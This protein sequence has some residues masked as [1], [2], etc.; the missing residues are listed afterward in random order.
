MNPWW[1][2]FACFMLLGVRV[3]VTFY[4]NINHTHMYL[5][6]LTC[7]FLSR[8]SKVLDIIMFNRWAACGVIVSCHLMPRVGMDSGAE[9]LSDYHAQHWYSQTVWAPQLLEEVGDI[10][11]LIFIE[12]T[13]ERNL[14]I[15]G[16]H[17][18]KTSETASWP[19]HETGVYLLGS[20][21]WLQCIL[22]WHWIPV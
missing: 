3:S 1:A 18:N 22:W 13:V 14:S 21:L 8:Y 4:I 19:L 10:I 7:S 12:Q 5:H 15:V 6:V 9:F 17:W 20:P 16:S 2:P 11:C